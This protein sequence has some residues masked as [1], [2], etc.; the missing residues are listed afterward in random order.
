MNIDVSRRDDI[1]KQFVFE[2]S[3]NSYKY[4]VTVTKDYYQKLMSESV[5]LEELVMKSF[6]FLLE[7]EG[8]ESIL[9]EFELSLIQYYFP[10]YEETIRKS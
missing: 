4:K 10:E 9:P 7:R 5:S 8:P 2:V 6:E 3:V 1:G